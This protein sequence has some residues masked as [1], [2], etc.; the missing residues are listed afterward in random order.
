MQ[1]VINWYSHSVVRRE[2]FRSGILSLLQY[3]AAVVYPFL[4][5][6]SGKLLFCHSVPWDSLQLHRL[7]PRSCC[8]V[9]ITR[10]PLSTAGGYTFLESRWRYVQHC[11]VAKP[12]RQ[13]V[14]ILQICGWISRSCC[15]ATLSLLRGCARRC[16]LTPLTLLLFAAFA[17][18][19]SWILSAF[20]PLVLPLFALLCAL[21]L[22]AMSCWLGLLLL[23]Q[24]SLLV[25]HRLLLTWCPA[26]CS[27]SPCRPR[28]VF[29]ALPLLV[30]PLWGC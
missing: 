27:L 16:T 8:Q 25:T 17:C 13:A 28:P 9:C 12:L 15:P 1:Y 11:S 21:L 6:L 23:M 14:R 26:A 10:P 18:R 3:P 20:C 24:Q 4:C 5:V 2:V 7:C 22:P 19:G 30:P 29:W